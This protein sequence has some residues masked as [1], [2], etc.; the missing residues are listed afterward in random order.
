M[1]TSFTIPNQVTFEEAIALTQLLI[2]QLDSISEAEITETIS[3]LV[4]SEN[5]AR[6]FFVTYLTYEGPFADHPTSSVLQA[7]RSSP[8]IVADL[9]VKNLAMSTAMAIEHRRNQNET[10]AQSSDRVRSRSFHLIQQ[11]NLPELQQRSQVLLETLVKGTGPD[12]KFLE[13]WGYDPEQRQAIQ[14]VLESL[15][16]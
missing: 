6:G 16:S 14:S 4:A 13:R 9:L 12:R 15:V 2:S 3:A 5:G 10:L 1:Q 8:L 11:L 7:L